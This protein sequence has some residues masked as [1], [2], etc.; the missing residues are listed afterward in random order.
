MT[1]AQ[2]LAPWHTLPVLVWDVETTG[3]DPATDAIVQVGC[4]LY[5][6]G[7]LAGSACSLVNPGRP[8]PEAAT[9]IHGITDAMVADAPG[10]FAAIGKVAA[11]AD[12]NVLDAAGCAYNATF[13]AAF[14]SAATRGG[15]G[16]SLEMTFPWL[17]P[18]VM[19]RVA[20]KFVKGKG[21]H[22]LEAACKRRGI[23]ISG[24]HN[25]QADAIATG[26]LL[27]TFRKTL[28]DL[29][30]C[31]VLRR[32]ENHRVS[33]EREFEEWRSKQPPLETAP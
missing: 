15:Y 23:E 26:A 20:D 30:I 31:E 28:G 13:D 10:A 6:D 1:P 24:A 19:V 2:L 3:V 11:A 8:I 21:R 33:Q 32:Q 25:A 4:A 14:L 17:D 5:V 7:E 9:A 27:F 29:T 22:K 16:G 18:L 12:P